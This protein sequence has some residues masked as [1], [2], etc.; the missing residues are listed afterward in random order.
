[1]S[2]PEVTIIQQNKRLRS[3]HSALL[4]LPDLQFGSDY[5]HHALKA[6][7]MEMLDRAHQYVQKPSAS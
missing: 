2:S 6:P 1:M 3:L 4:Q 7:H 5:G